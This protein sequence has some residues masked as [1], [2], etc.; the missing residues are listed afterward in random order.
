MIFFFIKSRLILSDPPALPTR[1]KIRQE[2]CFAPV[3]NDTLSEEAQVL[4]KYIYRHRLPHVKALISWISK[5]EL[6][7]EGEFTSGLTKTNL[8]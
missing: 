5:E 6:T 4:S 1:G 7:F 8:P 2:T 3:V